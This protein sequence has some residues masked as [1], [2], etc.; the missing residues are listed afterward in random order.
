MFLSCSLQNHFIS[1]DLHV[2]GGENGLHALQSKRVKECDLWMKLCER[3]SI[4][5][6][7]QVH[8][9]WNLLCVRLM[10]KWI[11]LHSIDIPHILALTRFFVFFSLVFISWR[12]CAHVCSYA[13][14]T[15]KVLA[16]C[17][18]SSTSKYK[19]NQFYYA[20]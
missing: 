20:R 8:L 3:L 16:I 15:W 13:W 10:N 6:G 17:Q 1:W 9:M 5:L 11:A 4:G 2:A 7:F 18:H 12:E 19:H 14:N